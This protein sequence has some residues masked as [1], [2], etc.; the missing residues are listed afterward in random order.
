MWIPAISRRALPS[1]KCPRPK[2]TPTHMVLQASELTI[3]SFVRLADEPLH[4]TSDFFPNVSLL[5][6][7]LSG[8][9]ASLLLVPSVVA[10]LCVLTFIEF[11]ALFCGVS[12]HSLLSPMLIPSSR[13]TARSDCHSVSVQ[14]LSRMHSLLSVVRSSSRRPRS[15]VS[16]HSSW[17][18]STAV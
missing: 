10:L 13:A 7:S 11:C 6:C 16:R 14:K 17:P 12:S 1:G 5:L 8:D 18:I 4:L 9:V 2:A 3:S 15:Q